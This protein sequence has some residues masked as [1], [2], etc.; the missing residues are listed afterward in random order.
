MDPTAY[1][2]TTARAAN[3]DEA[4]FALPQPSEGLQTRNVTR[5]VKRRQQSV[6]C[7][8]PSKQSSTQPV[9]RCR[10]T[11]DVVRCCAVFGMAL[12]SDDQWL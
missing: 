10:P 4:L 2:R 7:L 1:Q 12:Q 11:K 6:V 5:F 9:D 3:A 8:R